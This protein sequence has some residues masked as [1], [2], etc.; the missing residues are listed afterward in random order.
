MRRSRNVSQCSAIAAIVGEG[1][2]WTNR[3]AFC[4]VAYRPENSSSSPGRREQTDGIED[5][6]RRAKTR[7][8]TGLAGLTPRAS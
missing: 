4:R 3:V 1:S 2:R 5:K 6:T 7:S 8:L